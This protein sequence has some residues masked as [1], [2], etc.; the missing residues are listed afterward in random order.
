MKKLKNYLLLVGILGSL[1]A[2][3]AATA[4]S[5]AAVASG[6]DKSS[7]FLGLPTWYKY[8]DVGPNKNGDPCAVQLPSDPKGNVDWALTGGRIGLA[9][10]EILL[11][12]AGVVSVAFVIYGGINLTLSEGDPEKA[13]QGRGTII[14]A[15]IGLLIVILATAVVNFVGNTLK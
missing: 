6:C 3:L 9:V 5:Y 7:S 4:T 8:L 1:L 2:P 14:N 10:I 12:I 13:K 15:L 11:R